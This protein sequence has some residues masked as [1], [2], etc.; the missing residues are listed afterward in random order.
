[1]LARVAAL[2]L[3]LLGAIS[4]HATATTPLTGPWD[5]VTFELNSWGKPVVSWIV[6]ADGSGSWSE[7]KDGASFSD[8]SV[9]VHEIAADKAHHEA[10][11]ALLKRLPFPAPVTEGCKNFMTDAPYGRIRLTH[12]ATTVELAYNAGCMDAPY[13]A[14]LDV[15]KA[16][17]SLVA[18]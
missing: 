18:E 1:M 11:A 4:A 6:T 17:E 9:V 8:Y 16:A 13:V 10:L 12:G 7:T 3:T 14:Y 2:M 15:L 5:M